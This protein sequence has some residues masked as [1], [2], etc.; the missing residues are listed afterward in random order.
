MAYLIDDIDITDT[1]GII[2][3][4]ISGGNIALQGCFDMP[5]RI[6][7]ISHDWGDEDGLEIYTASGDLFYGGRDISFEGLIMGDRASIYGNLITLYG[8]I[9]AATGLSVFS[10]PYGDFNVYPKMADPSH[11]RDI[12]KLRID[13]REPAPDMTGGSLPAT[14]TDP[15]MIDGIPMASFGLYAADYKGVISLAEMKEQTFT[16][17]EAEGYKLTKRKA[18]KVELT[19][20]IIAADLNAFKVHVKNLYALFRS[21]GERTFTLN[22]QVIIVGALVNGFKIDRVMIANFIIA[23]FKCDITPTSMT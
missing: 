23:S 17:I 22:N 7:D 15:Y 2:P 6:G 3:G 13:F 19:C 12:S 16:K 5:S 4:H 8:D 20:W 10:T 9:T 21:A 11:F 1:Y 14:H 18:G